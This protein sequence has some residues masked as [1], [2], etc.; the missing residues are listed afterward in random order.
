MLGFFARLFITAFGLFLADILLR[1][2]RFEGVLSL[3]LAA[4]LLG[5]VNAFV[6]PIVILLTLPITL[7]TL[8]LF[9]LV[10]NGAM[11]L[12]VSAIMPSF[13]SDGLGPSILAAIL[14]GLTGWAAN[15][16]VGSQGKVEVWRIR[17][18]SG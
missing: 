14:V 6:R 1:G 3:W 13:H 12:L 7:V 5:I 18:G 4:F 15:A 11:V 2:I 9:L 17:R 16:F 10:V 8:G